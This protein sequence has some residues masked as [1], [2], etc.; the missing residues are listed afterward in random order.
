MRVQALESLR[1]PQITH[2]SIWCF[3]ANKLAALLV[4]GLGVGDTS[5]TGVESDSRTLREA[6]QKS[7]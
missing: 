6:E 1:N 3:L 2:N 7:E 4:K 5:I